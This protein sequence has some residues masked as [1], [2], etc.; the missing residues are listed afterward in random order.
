M[1]LIP[2]KL[3]SF[4]KRSYAARFLAWLAVFNFVDLAAT[5][6]AGRGAR[7]D[8]KRVI[9]VKLDGIGDYV[10][11]TSSFDRLAAIYPEDEFERVLVGNRR[12]QSLAQDEDLFDHKIFVDTDRFAG[13]IR[14]RYA[15][16]RRVRELGADVAV[17][18]RLTRELLWS[19]SLVRAT[20]APVRI[21]S[22]GLDNLM[23]PLADRISSRWYTKLVD[24]P[25]PGQ[26][27]LVS[28]RKFF[29][30][31]DPASTRSPQLPR[32][33]REETPIVGNYA[34]LVLGAFNHDRRW[35]IERFADVARHLS[36]EHRLDIVICGGPADGM[37]AE[38]FAEAYPQKA[39]D[40]VGQTSLNDLGSLLGGA[41]LTVTND[42]GVAHI[43]VAAGCATVVVTPGNQVG[44][45]FPYP[46]EL[47]SGG[48]RQLS[49]FHE[50]PCFGCGWTCIYKDLAPDEPKPCIA[51][52]TTKDV[53]A[54]CDAVL[55]P[56]AAIGTNGSRRGSTLPAA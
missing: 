14:Y 24:A 52:V 26:H 19:D 22:R 5:A 42:T 12:W 53:I 49:V 13:D 47:Q 46:G 33:P 51:G 29:D 45:F 38:K 7:S 6:S 4:F 20:G 55:S 41:R 44:R 56:P 15:I 48:A 10:I 37:L 27:E 11:W 32:L 23:I 35:P 43:A 3:R 18:P 25:E 50:M 40:L 34:V 30:A 28:M 16:V 2:S 21:G 9:F 31:L 39:I 36:N 8:K 54:A 17:N 1:A